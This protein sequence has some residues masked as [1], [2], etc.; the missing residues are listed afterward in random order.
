MKN[1][2]FFII[3]FLCIAAFIF[4]ADKPWGNLKKIYFYDSVEDY[5]GVL[6]NLGAINRDG[7]EKGEVATLSKN[8]IEFGD[9]YF[10][11]KKF[12]IAEAFYRKVL[13]LSPDHWYLYNKLEEIDR[14]KGNFFFNFN[15]SRSYMSILVPS[16]KYN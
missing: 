3:L 13:D 9:H 14:E 2:W 10:A 11:Q 7:L 16:V 8:L 6:E 12:D 1:K 4:P 5:P 15:V